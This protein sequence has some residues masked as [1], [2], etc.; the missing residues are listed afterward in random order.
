MLRE[1]FG[2]LFSFL[3]RKSFTCR[4]TSQL[5]GKVVPAAPDEGVAVLEFVEEVGDE[6]IFR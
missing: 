5:Q 2:E 1:K 3:L 4:R 6:A